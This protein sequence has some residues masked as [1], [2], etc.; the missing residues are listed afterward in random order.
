MC[1]SFEN[2]KRYVYQTLDRDGA[3]WNDKF[4]DHFKT[5]APTKNMVEFKF[6]NLR[7]WSDCNNQLNNWVNLNALVAVASNLETYI[8]TIVRLAIES[9]VGVLYGTPQRV[10]GIELV[11]RNHPRAFQYDEIVKSIT[12]G[13]WESRINAYERLFDF[14]PDYL[15]T[16][17][18]KLDR[19]RVIRNRVAHAFGRE[20]EASRTSDLKTQPV[21]KLSQS[22]MLEYQNLAWNTAREIDKHL[23]KHIGEYQ[24]LLFYHD[25]RAKVDHMKEN[26]DRAFHLRKALGR[27]GELPP[28]KEFCQKLVEYYEAI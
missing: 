24:S 7:E 13:T 2:S 28:G 22:R 5:P 10:D 16:N 25:M 23:E 4:L 14:V 17:C 12:M 19:L 11:K 9:D 27:L 3:N 21:A 6:A 8:A 15:R 26:N 20:I 1:S 18:S